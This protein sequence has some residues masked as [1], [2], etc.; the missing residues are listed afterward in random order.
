[1]TETVENQQ[2]QT[3]EDALDSVLDIK[4]GDVVKG[5]VLAFEDNQ[6]RV[7]I[8]ESGGL[9]GVIP[10][11]ELSA[12]PFNEFTEVVNIGDEVEVVVLKP[13]RDKENGN[14][15]LSRKRLE[16]KKVWAELK[17]KFDNKEIIT[18]PVKE[19]V[20]GGLVVDLGL[21]AFVPASMVDSFYVEDLKV[22]VG[23]TL[24]FV[25][26]ELDE[27]ENRLILSHKEIAERERAEKRAAALANL[28]EGSIVEGTVARLTNFGA[29][30]N[31]GDVDGL[32]HLSR[33]SHSH[34]RKPGDVLNVGDKV[35]VKVL[36]VSPEDGR[37][38][39]SIKDTLEGPW[40]NIQEK[41]GEGTVL[42][43]T[44]KRLTDFGAFVE[45][46]PGVEG[47]VHISQISHEHIA[48]PGE[49]L[50]E[51]QEVDVK[52]L[53]VNPEDQRLSLS[54]KA[55]LERPARPEG[56]VSDKPKRE[57]KPRKPRAKAEPAPTI[58]AE[59]EGFTLGDVLAG[60]FGDLNTEE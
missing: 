48:T 53:S 57:S 21:R 43:G 46:L 25:I 20:K 7:S 35:N 42:K 26:V 34:I 9:E 12:K 58:V 38:S 4:P 37:V 2:L 56:E 31:L 8:K 18:A 11:R 17:E 36:S 10:R 39:L 28:V 32:V 3:M 30:V 45:V 6:V 55:L 41:A 19:A 23:Q 5:D 52:V 59:A 27:K 1:M 16:S 15:L 47:L 29:F 33:I 22:Y 44:V 49:K 14:F 54:I 50:Q 24:D 51:G 13:I 60:A 40:D